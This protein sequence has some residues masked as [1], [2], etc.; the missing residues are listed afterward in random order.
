MC[1]V[2]EKWQKIDGEW[3]IV[4]VKPSDESNT[5]IKNDYTVKTSK[6]F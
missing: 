5:Y 3:K 6:M 1:E 2:I 4:D